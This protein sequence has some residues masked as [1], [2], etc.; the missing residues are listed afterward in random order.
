[1][2][3][4][5]IEMELEKQEVETPEGMERT[6][7]R[8]VYIPRVDIYESGDNVIL[9][10]DMPGVTGDGVD[11]TLEKNELTIKGY[12]QY[13]LPADHDLAYAEYGIGDYERSFVLSQEVDRERIEATM[14]HGV[15]RLLLPKAEA[16]KLR[17]IAVKAG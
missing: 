12:P 11:I 4:H 9:L 15:L 10:A 13:D 3:E 8:R 1:M 17:K 16:A 2:S 6:H 14:K 7:N 5:T